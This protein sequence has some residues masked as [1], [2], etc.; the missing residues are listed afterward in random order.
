MPIE[1]RK[2]SDEQ[3]DSLPS[4]TKVTS[5]LSNDDLKP[6]QKIVTVKDLRTALMSAVPGRKPTPLVKSREQVAAERIGPRKVLFR[7]RGTADPG[8]LPGK[9][10]WQT[11]EAV[12]ARIR[13]LERI[14]P[15]RTVAPIAAYHYVP[16]AYEEWMVARKQPFR[17]YRV[18]INPTKTIVTSATNRHQK[19]RWQNRMPKEETSG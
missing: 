9:R 2:C 14:G 10:R 4:C 15:F 11:R 5:D 6:G 19:H 8:T 13:E 18:I 17:Q 1:Q 16:V 3:P 12:L 7:S